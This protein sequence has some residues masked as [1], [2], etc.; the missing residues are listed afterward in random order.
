[1]LRDLLSCFLWGR[2]IPSGEISHLDTSHPPP[3]YE[4]ACTTLS[5]LPGERTDKDDVTTKACQAKHAPVPRKLASACTEPSESFGEAGQHSAHNETAASLHELNESHKSQMGVPGTLK[6]SSKQVE[7]PESI[8]S[9][10]TSNSLPS[11][12]HGRLRNRNLR[13]K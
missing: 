3:T 4:E 6:P 10:I 12:N 11:Q 5:D 8:S 9:K 1:M 7:F 13:V 2:G